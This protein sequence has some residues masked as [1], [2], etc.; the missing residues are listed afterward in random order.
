[1]RIQE[2]IGSQQLDEDLKSKIGAGLLAAGVGLGGYG[3]YKYLGQP[4]QQQSQQ[5]TKPT[6]PVA[7]K[8]RLDT[9][10]PKQIQDYLLQV[11]NTVEWA[12]NELRQFLAQSQHETRNFQRMA[13]NL[14]YVEPK[15]LY[16]VFTSAFKKNPKLAERYVGDP[17]ALANLV[18][19]N[20]NGNGDVASGDG[21]RYHGRG[22]LQITGKANYAKVGRGIG[23]DLISKPELLETDPDVSARAA[24]WYWKNVVHPRVGGRGKPYSDTKAS[25]KP[26]SP[27]LTGL[28]N[29]EK[30]YRK[31]DDVDLQP[32]DQQ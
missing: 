18:Y 24:I 22:F 25:T 28:K 27:A 5:S 4:Q 31:L 15:R 8:P 13:E 17:E 14:Y 2:V 16:K 7:P 1:M 11:A 6:T 12:P 21:W 9:M 23:V 3:A 32:K 10:A 19:A 30:N 29:R 20:K 26:I